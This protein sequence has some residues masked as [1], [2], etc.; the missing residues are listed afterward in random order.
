L[1]TKLISM[2]ILGFLLSIMVCFAKTKEAGDLW[3]KS[4][5]SLDELV[6]TLS[7]QMADLKTSLSSLKLNVEKI[8][9]QNAD[10]FSS[11]KKV[12]ERVT[13]ES[14]KFTAALKSTQADLKNIKTDIVDLESSFTQREKDVRHV[15][16]EVGGLK[17]SVVQVNAKLD[18]M[19]KDVA[20]VS[21]EGSHGQA[22]C[23]E[24]C[25][26]T[27]GR[28]SKYNWVNY[29]NHGIYMDVSISRCG[30]IKT[31]TV[32]TSIEGQMWHWKA[33]GTSSVYSVTPSKFR[34]YLSLSS[35]LRKETARYGGWNVEW[36][37]VGYTC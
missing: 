9:K 2:T 22:K 24:V 23:A 33:T 28:G 18:N 4:V 29:D 6:K 15:K 27:T 12:N 8:E 34:I 14:V 37:A 30:F 10:L 13:K 20:V 36:I 1:N 35:K 11:M 25:A 26:G 17:T 16:T 32:T 31:P 21:V 3:V 7:V 19:R 5:V